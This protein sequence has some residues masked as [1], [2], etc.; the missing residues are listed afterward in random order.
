MATIPM[1]GGFAIVPEGTHVFRIYNVEYDPA[2]GK[3]VVHMVTAQGIVHRERFGLMRNDGSMNEG[4][5]NAFSF[6][7]K[8]ALDN[9]GLEEIDHT[10][11][12]NHYI[13]ADV[14]HTK[15]E[16]TKEEGKILTFAKLENFAVAKEFDTT[17]VAKALTLGTTPTSA[18]P[19]PAPTP[20]ENKGVDLASLLG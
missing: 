17:P 3:L 4:A 10:D 1:T 12:I 5:C 18:A 9:F 16:S 20:A 13:K 11:L 7:A 19:T 15:T 14:T 6:F 2:F 8:T